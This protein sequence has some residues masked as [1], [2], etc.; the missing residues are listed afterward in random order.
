MQKLTHKKKGPEERG[1][2]VREQIKARVLEIR[3]RDLSL[4]RGR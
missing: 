4:T 3:S 2:D 1:M